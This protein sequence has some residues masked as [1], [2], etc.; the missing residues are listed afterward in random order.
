M[1]IY[2]E[3]YLK[4]RFRQDQ[5]ALQ[6]ASAAER[7]REQANQRDEQRRISESWERAIERETK[8]K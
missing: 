6:A 2:T 3:L 4:Q 1:S 7:E 5:A 8:R